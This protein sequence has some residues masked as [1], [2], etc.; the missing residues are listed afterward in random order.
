MTSDKIYM[1]KQDDKE[2]E[3]IFKP[4]ANRR[5]LAI[6]R[7]I[8]KARSLSVDEIAKQI[9]L[10]FRSTSRHLAILRQADL[11][12]FEMVKLQRFYHMSAD[13]NVLSKYIVSQL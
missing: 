11:V 5:R 4:L 8:I 1:I 9:K 2:L 3:K 6:L 7:C 12:E 10:S 13:I